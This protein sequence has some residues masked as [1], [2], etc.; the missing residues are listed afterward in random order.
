MQRLN[1]VRAIAPFGGRPRGS[2]GAS[3]GFGKAPL[4]SFAGSSRCLGLG[5]RTKRGRDKRS[6]A[7]GLRRRVGGNSHRSDALRLDDRCFVQHAGPPPPRFVSAPRPRG[8][9][10]LAVLRRLNTVIRLML[11]VGCTVLSAR[12]PVS[13][14][15][16]FC[17]RDY[18]DYK[19]SVRPLSHGGIECRISTGL[20][21]SVCCSFL[22]LSWGGGRPR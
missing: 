19:T 7:W 21:R 16:P 18:H 14:R 13:A 5:G 15:D 9:V 6:G 20:P 11:A 12:R 2:S 1:C 10:P 8:P 3:R 17:G 4:D 22:A